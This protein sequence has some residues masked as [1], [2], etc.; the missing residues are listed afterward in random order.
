[1]TNFSQ[2]INNLGAEFT[3]QGNWNNTDPA[4]ESATLKCFEIL[5]ATWNSATLIAD[6]NFTVSVLTAPNTACPLAVHTGVAAKANANGIIVGT[7]KVYSFGGVGV[8]E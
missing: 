6:G 8:V 2:I 4:A 1:M 3:S 5:D 7:S